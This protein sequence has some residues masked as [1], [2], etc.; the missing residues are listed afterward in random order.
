MRDFTVG[1]IVT[2]RIRF[3][4]FTTFFLC[5]YCIVTLNAT[6]KDS[7]ISK[8]IAIPKPYLLI[9][10]PSTDCI[11]CKAGAG[12]A[13]RKLGEKIN[14]KQLIVL[15][16]QPQM[17]LYFSKYKKIYTDY[18]II[19][20]SVL[21]MQLAED[22]RCK[23]FLVTNDFVKEIRLNS[24][25]DSTIE[26]ILQEIGNANIATCDSYSFHDS[27]FTND[28]YNIFTANKK[29]AFIYSPNFQFGNV[30]NFET[31]TNNYIQPNISSFG[32][33]KIQ[34]IIKYYHPDSLLPVEISN[35]KLDDKALPILY[36]YT[37]LIK[38]NI[39]YSL[40]YVNAIIEEK[41]ANANTIRETV[42]GRNFIGKFTLNTSNKQ[43]NVCDIDSADELYFVD[44][45]HFNNHLFFPFFFCGF[46]FY[47][48][49]FY[50]P[51]RKIED[52]FGVM[53]ES[54]KF[55]VACYSFSEGKKIK[56]KYVY[57]FDTI[58][59]PQNFVLRINTENGL[60]VIV[61]KTHG[62]VIEYKQHSQV[63]ITEISSLNSDQLPTI[64]DCTINAYGINLIAKINN[65]IVLTNA[66]Q[67]KKNYPIFDLTN[68]RQKPMNII[69]C[70]DT[71]ISLEKRGSVI[72]LHKYIAPSDYLKL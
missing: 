25:N 36:F 29:N 41:T 30:I 2:M 22:M 10:I 49:Q 19:I 45:M 54:K 51:V 64:Y 66:N 55:F 60:P 18:E 48:D 63:K 11:N 15:S 50:I 21:S 1:N 8:I 32:G 17:N 34:E 27:L 68:E 44:T 58:T 42:K 72:M 71:I 5:F 59:R 67:V 35:S 16:D 3:K 62:R 13:L 69:Y 52:S 24:L 53:V 47:K 33:K 23:L 39:C 14:H 7:L 57:D 61:D 20:D 4:C 40:F 28:N 26:R 12:D 37:F 6:V 31:K 46:E 38:N 56:V 70:N 9:D 43:D 65:K